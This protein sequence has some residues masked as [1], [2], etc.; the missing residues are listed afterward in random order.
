M[1]ALKTSN[2][3]DRNLIVSQTLFIILNLFLS[4]VIYLRCR[5]YGRSARRSRRARRS[6]CACR[7]RLLYIWIDDI[8]IY[9]NPVLII[10]KFKFITP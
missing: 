1:F 10:W 2:H 3:F 6:R 8:S 5:R 4:Y 7:C 9:M